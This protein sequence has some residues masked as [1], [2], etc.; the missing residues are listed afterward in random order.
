MEAGEKKAVEKHLWM[1]RAQYPDDPDLPTIEATLALGDLDWHKA[2]RILQQALVT[3]PS[4][5]GSLLMLG[6]IYLQLQKY[7]EAASLYSRAAH[8]GN[9]EQQAQID[10]LWPKL[11]EQ[12]L[13]TRPAVHKLAII[14]VEG[15]QHGVYDLAH[16]LVPYAAVRL[17][18]CRELEDMDEAVAWADACWFEGASE[19]LRIAS[20]DPV[21]S[22]KPIVCRM[23]GDEV[24]SPM[25]ISIDWTA[26]N[27]LIVK[28]PYQRNLLV[29]MVPGLTL[30]TRVHVLPEAIDVS[31]YPMQARQKGFRIAAIGPI[32]GHS[33]PGLMLQILARL[34]QQHSFYHLHIAGR[35]Q[36]PAVRLY[37]QNTVQ[38]LGLTDHVHLEGPQEDLSAWLADK[39]Y[40]LCTSLHERT[41][42]AIPE[43]MACGI[44]PVVHF[45]PFAETIWPEEMLFTSIDEA[46]SMITTEQ[47]TSNAYHSFVHEMYHLD[48][49][50]TKLRPILAGLFARA[51]TPAPNRG[52]AIPD[53]FGQALRNLRAL[54]PT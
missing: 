22:A 8:V 50:V 38:R 24:F 7:T 44:K 16:A 13:D 6:N 34:V 51:T 3:L 14:A 2:I 47:Y 15:D 46:L 48:G 30:T 21:T 26:V 33:N 54:Q 12:G 28:Q 1:H 36:D 52:P 23:L 4:H 18:I 53:G 35:F 32:Y 25:P 5:F 27:H 42:S 29:E 39:D 49:L 31:R 37:W 41:G 9:A 11:S 10:A 19:L 45:H 20:E 17:F 43:A 40:L